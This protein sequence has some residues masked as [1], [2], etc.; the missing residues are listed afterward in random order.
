MT[1]IRNNKNN[2]NNKEMNWNVPGQLKNEIYSRVNAECSS[3]NVKGW[4]F[5]YYSCCMHLNI[6]NE[7]NQ[8]DDDVDIMG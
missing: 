1:K 5:P 2:N 6:H 8:D 3:E 7:S 4:C